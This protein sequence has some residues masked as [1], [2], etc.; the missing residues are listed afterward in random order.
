M[1]VIEPDNHVAVPTGWTALLGQITV[2]RE[3]AIYGHRLWARQ[4]PWL[5][6]LEFLNVAEAHHRA[7]RLLDRTDPERTHP[8]ELRFRMGLRNILFTNVLAH[9]NALGLEGENAWAKWRELIDKEAMDAPAEGFDYVRERFVEFQDFADLVRLVRQTTLE[10][11]ST[12]RWSS[13]FIFPFGID[14]LYSDAIVVKDRTTRDF[15]V[16][17]RTGELLYHMI[18]RS[19]RG[20]ELVPYLTTLFDPDAPKNR[21]V[22]LLS[23][24]S[25]AQAKSDQQG[26]SF[27]PY[28]THPAFDRLAE[29]WLAVLELGLPEQDAFAHLAPLASL[30]VL[31]YQLET[32]A[33]WA[34]KPRP[35]MI[36]EIIA[37]KRE[38]VRQRSIACFYNNDDLSRQAASAYAKQR[39]EALG[40]PEA[41]DPMSEAERIEQA[42]KVLADAFSYKPKTGAPASTEALYEQFLEACESKHDENWSE[43]HAAYGRFIGLVSRRA[44]NRYRY[45]PTDALI[46]T[47][48]MARVPRRVEFGRF[49]AD[50]YDHYGFVFGPEEAERALSAQEFDLAAFRAN[51]RRLEARLSSMGLLKRLSD[52]CAYVENPLG[53][54]RR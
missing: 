10:A 2:W 51:R 33:I 36:C 50:L 1:S 13:R 7:G 52:G 46:K 6:L 24:P 48:V 42:E 35:H 19:G 25:D 53:L 30:H 22:G 41:G 9:V 14:A 23:A 27:L 37:P 3:E 17:G 39:I 47:L 31:L 21:L 18:S 54:A 5:L 43:I 16:F 20:A 12:K 29:D 15:T 11:S 8:Y 45:A 4:N 40:W 28:R 26:N 49:L 44:T 38:L 34:G 32:S